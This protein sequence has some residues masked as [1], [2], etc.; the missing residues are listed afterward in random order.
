M[1]LIGVD[2]PGLVRSVAELV[3]QHGG[4]WLESR[5]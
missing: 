1:T 5:M 4:N 2:R 3:V